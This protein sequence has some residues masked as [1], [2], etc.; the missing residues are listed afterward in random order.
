MAV[1]TTMAASTPRR[2]S[3]ADNFDVLENLDEAVLQDVFGILPRIGVADGSCEELTAESGIQPR[4]AEG[5]WALH[6]SINCLTSSL[7]AIAL[8]K[9]VKGGAFVALVSVELTPV[10]A[11]PFEGRA[12]EHQRPVLLGQFHVGFEVA[13]NSRSPSGKG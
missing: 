13:S 8:S 5:R 1:L 11:E 6:P 12:M 4:W 10:D 2:R 9:N 7:D 3:P